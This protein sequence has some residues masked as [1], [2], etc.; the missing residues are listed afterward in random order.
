MKLIFLSITNIISG[1]RKNF[2]KAK[3]DSSQSESVPG[4]VLSLNQI[5]DAEDK[6]FI[7]TEL[8]DY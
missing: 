7:D 5:M 3:D 8:G 1:I 4:E 2:R 6:P